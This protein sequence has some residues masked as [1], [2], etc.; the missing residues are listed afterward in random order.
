MRLTNRQW[1]RTGWRLFIASAG[2]FMVFAFRAGDVVGFLDAC[3]FMA[4]NIAFLVPF[5]GRSTSDKRED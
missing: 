2:L 3:A 4:A 5:F 1:T